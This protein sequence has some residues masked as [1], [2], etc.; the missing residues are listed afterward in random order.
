MARLSQPQIIKNLQYALAEMA[1][2]AL[3][4]EDLNRAL[5]ARNTELSNAVRKQPA[6]VD[7]SKKLTPA[8]VRRLRTEHK[9]GLLSQRELAD[10]YEVHPATVSRIVRGVYHAHVR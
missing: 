4:F 6:Y 2:K 10:I 1:G 9:A 3:S 8:D 7:N 5:I